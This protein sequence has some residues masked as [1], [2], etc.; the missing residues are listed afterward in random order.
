MK[1]ITLNRND[2]KEYCKQ[3]YYKIKSSGMQPDLILAIKNGGIEI[4]EELYR[5]F[6]NE[7]CE[8]Q[9]CHPVR[10]KSQNKKI[11]KD[12]ISNLPYFILDYIRIF[13][14]KFLFKKNL[15]GDFIKIEFPQKLKSYKSILIVDDAIDSGQTL[16][17]VHKAIEQMNPSA[18]LKSCVFTITRP[19]PLIRPDFY[20]YNDQILIRFPWSIDSK[21]KKDAL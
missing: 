6:K 2:I 8:F 14:A 17:L 19:N 3:L 10:K 4:G 18:T 1:V 16:N 13:E 11:L 15:R 7:N 12:L 5:N 9:I 20:L 21:K